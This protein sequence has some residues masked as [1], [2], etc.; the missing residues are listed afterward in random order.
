MMTLTTL[1]ERISDTEAR[2]QW[3]SGT[4]RSGFIN[5]MLNKPQTESALLGELIAIRYLLFSGKAFDR[6][7]M[8]GTGV[9]LVVSRGAIKKLANNRSDKTYLIPVAAFL[10]GRMSGAEIVVSQSKDVFKLAEVCEEET[11]IASDI[12]NPEFEA[13][14]LPALGKVVITDH[15]LSQFINRAPDCGKKPWVSLL[16]RASNER[17]KQLPIPKN[18]LEHKERKYGR[19]DNVE[20]WGHDSSPFKFLVINEEGQS[21]RLVTVFNRVDPL[22]K[23]VPGFC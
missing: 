2:V 23:Y 5:V 15:A 11:I 8:G 21:R 20:L 1:S 18:V 16:A 12:L 7:N 22:P 3:F 14:D 4:K 17:L 6:K 9:R 10:Q 13:L 19:A